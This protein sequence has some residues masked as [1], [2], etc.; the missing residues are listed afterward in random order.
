MPRARLS[1]LLLGLFR[2]VRALGDTRRLAAPIAQV[3]ELGAAHL[4]ATHDLDGVDVRRIDREDALHALAVGDLANG[5]A[6]LETAAL[7]GEPP[8]VDI[9]KAQIARPG[10]DVSLLTYGGTVALALEAARTLEA[11]GIQAEVIDLRVLR[12]L[13]EATILESV[14][15]TRRAVVIDEAW[16]SGSLAAEVCARIA[17]EAFYELEAPP[18]RVCSAEVPMPYAKHLEQAAL[19]Q[20]ADVLDAVRGVLA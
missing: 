14:R 5:E 7:T 16:R 20:L 6:L 10:R 3:I 9:R 8:E 12:P 17:E 15:R 13:D 18:T 4:A 19:P 1:I 11:E 2:A